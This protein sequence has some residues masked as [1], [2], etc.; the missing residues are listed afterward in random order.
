[1][2]KLTEFTEHNARRIA[3]LLETKG[4]VSYYVDDGEG[5]GPVLKEIN[6]LPIID[7]LRKEGFSFEY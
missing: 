2:K 4:K 6:Q 5:Q 1:M 7:Y 3:F